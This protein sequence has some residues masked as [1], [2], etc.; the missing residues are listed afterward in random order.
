[1]AS[2]IAAAGIATTEIYRVRRALN[3]IAVEGRGPPASPRSAACRR[4]GGPA[5]SSSS[6]RRTPPACRSSAPR[7]SGATRLGS[8]P[9]RRERASGSASSTPA[10]TI[11]TP[12]FGGTGAAGRLPGQ[13][14]HGRARRLL[15]DRQGGGRQTTSPAMPTPAAM[16]RARSRPDGLQRPRHARRRHGG[17]LGVN[18]DGT[19]FAGP[20]D[21]R[22]RSPRCASA[23]ARRRRRSST[24]CASSAAAAARTSPCRRSTGRWIRTTTTTCP[25]TST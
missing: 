10:S 20:Y 6:T 22:R 19:T 12:T 9:A 3:A 4:Q 16:P 15:P 18:A 5:C 24:R 23:P 8:P 17:G 2:A 1:M 14:P 25:I 21:P 11:S 13:R 7:R